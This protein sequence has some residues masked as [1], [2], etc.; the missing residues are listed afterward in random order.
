[1]RVPSRNLRSCPFARESVDLA[2]ARSLQR[3]RRLIPVL[4]ATRH[5]PP[6][7]G[8]VSTSTM[9]INIRRP[10]PRAA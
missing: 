3:R 2:L 1:M 6:H 9:P 4:S 7:P 8:L 10:C 5:P